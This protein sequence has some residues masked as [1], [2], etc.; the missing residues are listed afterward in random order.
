MYMPMQNQCMTATTK[1]DERDP[2][3]VYGLDSEQELSPGAT[4]QG[5][6]FAVSAET[7]KTLW[8]LEQRA[9]VMSMV[10]TGGGLVFGGDVA[11]NLRAYDEKTGEVLWETNLGSPVTGYPM[12][13]AVDGTQYLAVST[14]MSSVSRA[15]ARLA[16][17]AVSSGAENRLF[18]F[19][20][21]QAH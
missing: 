20:L 5:A 17:E 11:G 19:A 18:V 15:A 2:S 12:T 16:A 14:G 4:G 8:R 6:I 1:S 13:Y 21:P 3:L 9:G 7:G 10:A